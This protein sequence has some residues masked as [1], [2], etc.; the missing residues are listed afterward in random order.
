MTQAVSRQS[1]A[2]TALSDTLPLQVSTKR[3]LLQL[4]KPTIIHNTTKCLSVVVVA[5]PVPT[6]EVS[7][8][9]VV[10]RIFPL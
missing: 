6:V 7:A 2:V 8:V 4:Y 9:A 10:V 5:H 3:K 1:R